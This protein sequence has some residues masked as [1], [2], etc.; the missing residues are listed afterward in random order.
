M[1]GFELRSLTHLPSPLLSNTSESHEVTISREIG[2]F[3]FQCS[4]LFSASVFVWFQ[5]GQ[6][7]K[8][9][10]KMPISLSRSPSSTLR[11]C[12]LET[13]SASAEAWRL[14]SGEGS[15]KC[16]KM[17]GCWRVL[18]GCLVGVLSFDI[19]LLVLINAEFRDETQATGSPS[20]PA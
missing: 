6:G 2:S 12:C 11:E 10:W 3:N 1:T 8:C 14:S 4:A 7:F 9:W 17:L 5:L 20:L 15:K 18:V 19:A 16:I 13:S